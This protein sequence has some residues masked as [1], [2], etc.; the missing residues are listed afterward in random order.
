[1]LEILGIIVVIAFAALVVAFIIFFY[2]PFG[3]ITILICY[4]GDLEST[5]PTCEV[6]DISLIIYFWTAVILLLCILI[7]YPREIV[8]ALHYMFIPHPAA[9]EV[10]RSTRNAITGKKDTLLDEAFR[11]ATINPGLFNLGS[12]LAR[13]NRARKARKLQEKLDA[14]TEAILEDTRLLRKGMERNRTLA[15]AHAVEEVAHE[16]SER[17]EHEVQNHKR[18]EVE[19][20]PRRHQ[21]VEINADEDLASVIRK[22]ETMR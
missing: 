2:L 17:L 1:M 22:L 8:T 18:R 19:R 10:R 16:L 9:K 15:A 4:L 21:R 7:A 3:W 12:V 20:M 11:D 13:R 5:S 14:N 6:A